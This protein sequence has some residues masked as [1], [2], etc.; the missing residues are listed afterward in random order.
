MSS[1]ITVSVLRAYARRNRG[2]CLTE[3]RVAEQSA[4]RWRCSRGHVWETLPR[5]VLERR[6]CPQCER[7][8]APA[9][10]WSLS[11]M[12]EAARGRGGE[13]LSE[14]YEHRSLPLQ[15]RCALGH[16]WTARPVGIV[17]G[18][19]WCPHCAGKL[20]LSIEDALRTARERGGAC[21]STSYVNVG[22]ALRWRCALDHEWSA[23]F[24]NVRAGS[25]CPECAIRNP[26]TIEEM[27][28]IAKARRGLCLST[29]YVN[30]RLKLRWRCSEGHEWDA[31][32]YRVAR[33]GQW[34]PRCAN[35]SPHDLEQVRALA[36]RR[37]GECL[38]R[39]YAGTDSKLR[40]RCARGHVWL[41]TPHSIDGKQSWCPT[42]A[43]EARQRHGA[44]HGAARRHGGAFLP[45]P[46]PKP[47]SPVRWRC[48]EGHVFRRTLSKVLA[49]VWCPQCAA[50][51]LGGGS[52]AARLR[53][54]CRTTRGTFT[55]AEALNA[56]SDAK[57]TTVRAT[58]GHLVRQGDTIERAG[59]PGRFRLLGSVRRA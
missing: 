17:K 37:G 31:S 23:P 22:R 58:L 41:A 53:A 56:L 36:A 49:G 15:W 35:E 50:Q 11:L 38:S 16:E 45:S 54:W 27:Q 14:A 25:W 52:V 34:C 42:C 24:N 26:C 39:R 47:S 48:A 51:P 43:V 3:G 12:R 32:G 33:E 55:M 4:V 59:V 1:W 30:A 13:C 8:R 40:W 28:S 19:T 5:V 44:F 7:G 21:L 2:E 29:E 57:P 10:R 18:G 9:R 20:K 6:W 46:A